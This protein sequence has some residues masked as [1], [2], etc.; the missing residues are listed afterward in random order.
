MVDVTPLSETKRKL[1]EKY[2]RGNSAAT[3]RAVAGIAP[4]AANVAPPVS[5]S[6]EQLLLRERRMQGG[7]ALYNECI[8]LRMKG[9]L[10]VLVLQESLCEIIRRHEIWRTS[11][12]IND[13][14]L[15]LT[16]HVSRENIELPVLDL[17]GLPKAQAD[18]EIQRVAGEAVR[19]PF[20]LKEGPL[21][22]A[23]LFR[24]ADMEHSMFLSAHLSIVDGVSVYQVFPSE[25]AALYRAYSSRQPSPLPDLTVQFG[26]YS[27]WQRRWLQGSEAA[28]QVAYWRKQLAG[29]IP[30]LEWPANRARPVQE[31]F[32]GV[33]Q[34]FA[35]RHERVEALAA[36]SR[37]EGATLFMGLLAG[38]VSLLHL[39]TQ[40]DDI[41]VGTPSPAGR[42]RSEVQKLLG[43]FLNPVGLRF[44]LTGDPTFRTVLEQAQRLTLEAISNDDVPLEV[45]ARELGGD[46]DRGR[47]PFFTVAMSLQPPMPELDLEWSV[48]SMDLG[49]GGS[50]W[51]L[52]LAFIH[53]PN[54]TVVRVQYDP[55][56][57]DEAAITRMVA[58]Y[59]TLL[60]AVNENPAARI[61]QLDLAAPARA[62]AGK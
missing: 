15:L 37:Q 25:L 18:A 57:F 32:G 7:P 24:T 51:D 49:S 5:L 6:Q 59:E 48:T 39:Y 52:Y 23:S 26:D 9:P 60:D 54:A 19:Q 14:R 38:L 3:A 13:G 35:L 58:D 31:K 16:T 50:P 43:Y 42:K 36:L 20:D 40:Q 17:R 41:I 12:H 61:S 46:V 44:D 1:L 11:Y 55:D 21:L 30:V 47:N 10:N 53:R 22:R 62:R 56:L 29:P 33:I 28:R 2:Y 27:H 45:V 34:S 8:R 4:R